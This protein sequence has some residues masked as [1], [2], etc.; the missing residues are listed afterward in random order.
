MVNK[1]KKIRLPKYINPIEYDLTLHPDINSYTFTGEETIVIDLE[2]PVRVLNI[3]AAELEILSA[4]YNDSTTGKVT[5]DESTETAS[6]KFS[7]LLPKGRGKL[8]LKFNGILNDKM[9]GFYRSKYTV[10][11]EDRHMAV[12]QFEATD[13]RRAF[14]C[15][16]EPAKKA[17]FYVKLVVP[18]DHTAISNTEIIDIKEHSSNFKVVHFS[19]T[20]IMSTYLLAFIVGKFEHIEREI[21]EGNLIRVFTTHGKKKQAE[22]ALDAACK[23]MSFY[24]KYFGIPFPIRV[25]DLIAIPDFAAGAMENWGAITYRETALLVDDEQTA[26]INKQWVALVIAHELAHQWF[27]NLVTMEWWTHLWLNEGFASYIEYLAVDHIFPEWN[28]W[29]QFVYMDQSRALELDGLKNTHPIEVEVHNPSEISEIFDAVSYSKGASIIRMLAEYLGQDVFRKGLQK[30]LKKHSYSNATTSDL[31][32]ALEKVSG[33]K[34]KQIMND[35]TKKAGYPVVDVTENKDG[36]TLTQSRFLSSAI[37]RKNFNDPTIWSIPIGV[38]LNTS[39][40]PNFILMQNKKLNHPIK[41]NNQWIKLNSGEKSLIRVNYSQ[42]NLENLIPAIEKKMIGP[43]DRYGVIRDLYVLA[44]AG[45]NSVDRALSLTKHY[46]QDDSYIVWVE[47]ATELAKLSNLLADEKNYNLFEDYA[48]NVFIPIGNK[49]GWDKRPGE[50][51]TET[52]LRNVILSSLIKYSHSDSIEKAKDLFK[53]IKNNKI[54]IDSDLRGIVYT[55]VARYGGEDIYEDLMKLYKKAALQE[56]KDRILK[57]LCSFRKPSLL[58]KTLKFAFSPEVRAQDSYK[59]ISLIFAN[60]NGRNLA[61]KFLQTKWDY[62]VKKYSGGHLFS[63][64]VEPLEFFTKKE[65]ANEVEA[66]FKSHTAPGAER[67]VKQVIEK[68]LSNDAWLKRDLKKINSFLQSVN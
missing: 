57:A 46:A 23:I 16:D 35:W 9:R 55:T 63:R 66:Y 67:T 49:V 58:N 11:G 21:P 25:L 43:E 32:D 14:P 50:S 52:L 47:I 36:F 42:E 60:P 26:T 18:E 6:I 39:K 65:Q 29:T 53:K 30:Y 5:Y 45:F 48:R 59:S 68:I 64:F 20:P 12:T 2:K 62:I 38:L 10:D 61:W 17:I 19:P 31:W 34:V 54:K 33:K 51:H 22:F 8:A 3:H 56:E 13:A 37:S 1:N 40:K 41:K 4:E 28:I 24:T 15:F 44:E 27:G 7:K